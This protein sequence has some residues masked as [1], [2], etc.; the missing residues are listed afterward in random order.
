MGAG[1]AATQL[2]EALLD[3]EAEALARTLVE[4]AL[5]GDPAMLRLAF[6]RAQGHRNPG[7]AAP[8][9]IRS[10]CPR[11]TPPPR[12]VLRPGPGDALL[13]EIARLAERTRGPPPSLAAAS[14]LALLAYYCFG[15]AA[16]AAPA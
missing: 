14:P 16:E 9:P 2:A 6:E 11:S 5:D 12:P 8:A 10:R 13:A 4:R 3:G 1:D 7:R 15:E